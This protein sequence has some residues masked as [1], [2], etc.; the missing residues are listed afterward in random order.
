M[1]TFTHL[2]KLGRLGNQLFQYAALKSIGL[3]TGYKVKIPDP[4][5]MHWQGQDC[6]LGKFNLEC[7][8]LQESDH[9]SIK[10]RFIEPSVNGF[11]PEIFYTCDNT[12][13][14][15]FFQNYKYFAEFEKQIKK[16]FELCD[17][18]RESAQSCLQEVL[19]DGDRD[20]E[21]VS[22]HMRRGDNLDG[23]NPE[24]SNFYGDNDILTPE[25]S[26]G[27]Y[28]FKAIEHFKDKNVKYLVF[29]G[30][31]RKIEVSNLSDIE[32]C[33]QNF[34]GDNVYYAEGN[35][36]LID[37]ALMSTCHHHI[38]CH[39]TS[40]GWWAAL[41]NKNPNKRVIAPQS[42]TIPD[43]KRYYSGFYPPDWKIIK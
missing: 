6:L 33:K 2:G 7:D 39:M 23:T 22:I 15:G 12:D 34:Y 16:E 25:S 13:F 29:S 27:K 31:S 8:H 21:I 28:F 42:Y 36:D 30:G 35:S 41:L 18:I 17:T 3:K 43:D 40:F 37:F 32:W 5:T 20:A 1:I 4:T 26:Y 14:Y 11:H 9:E 10:G 19:E 24:Y 38:T